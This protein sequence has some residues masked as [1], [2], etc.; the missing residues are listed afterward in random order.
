MH[1][2]YMFAAGRPGANRGPARTVQRNSKLADRV[3]PSARS[4]L[5]NQHPV[6]GLFQLN[7]NVP[8]STDSPLP[9]E[10]ASTS[11]EVGPV[12][13]SQSVAA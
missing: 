3:L 9:F 11:S 7:R 8:L 13:A 12:N 1:V 6:D 5:S 2:A 10:S 4:M